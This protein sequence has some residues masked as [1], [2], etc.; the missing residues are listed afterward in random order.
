L[1]TILPKFERVLLVRV[2][3]DQQK[4]FELYFLLEI[5]IATKEKKDRQN[6]SPTSI[7]HVGASRR[8]AEAEI[9]LKRA[10]KGSNNCG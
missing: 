5:S 8:E 10:A 2:T 3:T 7:H 4:R 1:E 9:S 6:S